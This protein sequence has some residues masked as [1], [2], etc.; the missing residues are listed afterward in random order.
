MDLKIEMDKQRLGE[1]MVLFKIKGEMDVFCSGEIKAEIIGAIA[2]G[3]HYLIIDLHW[4]TYMDST[5]LGI[6]ISALKRAREHG[7]N[8]CLLN[9]HH[10][11]KRMI[12]R[13][14]R[15]R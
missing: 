4:V 10:R 13:I 8:L 7:G 15:N 6:L 1:Q 14:G 3:D 12:N 11:V 5:G 2:E 9:P